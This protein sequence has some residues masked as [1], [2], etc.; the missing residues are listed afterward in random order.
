MFKYILQQAVKIK[1]EVKVDSPVR[2][3]QNT[4]LWKCQDIQLKLG[5]HQSLERHYALQNCFFL[6]SILFC[7]RTINVLERPVLYSL[8]LWA[9]LFRPPSF[10]HNWLPLSS[11]LTRI[12]VYPY[13]VSWWSSCLT[14][15][16]L[17]NDSGWP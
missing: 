4:G 16:F 17:S 3:V 9:V 7:D 2:W 13:C 12:F 14:F 6:C 5:H 8:V 1:A 11:F 10:S 15:H